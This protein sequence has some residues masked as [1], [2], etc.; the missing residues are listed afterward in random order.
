VFLVGLLLAKLVATVVT[1]GSGAVG[2]LIT[3]TFMLGASLGAAYGTAL[4]AC[5]L[6][7]GLPTSAFALVGMGSML[8]ATTHSPLLAMIMVF[9]I[10]LDYSLMP[11]L[12]LGCVVSILMSGRLHRDSIY[13]E[14]LR[15]RGLEL[16]RETTDSGVAIERTVGDLMH[17]PV[18][19]L[20]ENI[21]LAGI[22]ERFLTNANNF[23]PV[24]DGRGRL[25]G[26]VALQDL[27]E[28]LG[29]GREVPGVIAS[30]VM[31]PVP[32]FVTPGQR[33]TDVLPVV[34][35]SELRNI[36]V[37]N[38]PA[39][40]RLIGSLA[41]AEVLAILSEAIASGNNTGS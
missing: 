19:P 2:G 9:E 16:A 30:D 11:P 39:E 24:V 36:P 21:S 33:L 6:A 28:F 27:K 13:T 37:V 35:A 5:D 20:R 15:Q 4:H 12:M 23:L 3:P 32:R 26:V 7:L 41:R 40:Q 22:A 29:D 25:V 8:A 34:F 1:V 10:S 14:P 38:T 18:S 31:R 17:A